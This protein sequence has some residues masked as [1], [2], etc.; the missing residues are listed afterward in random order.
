VA[1]AAD[2]GADASLDADA[3][4]GAELADVDAPVVGAAADAAEEGAA[5]DAAGV[6]GLVVA[7]L[8]PHAVTNR[9]V[10]AMSAAVRRKDERG[11]NTSAFP[12]MSIKILG[13]MGSVEAVDWLVKW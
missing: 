3:D 6:A 4:E 1:A 2:A 10:A 8:P 11:L 13:S 5:P 12:V 9:A 7:A